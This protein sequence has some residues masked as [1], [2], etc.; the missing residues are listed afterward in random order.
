MNLNKLSKMLNVYCK[1]MIPGG[2]ADNSK[3]KFNPRA[4]NKGRKIEMEHTNDPEIAEE[5]AKDHLTED[6]EYYE[7]LEKY[8]EAFYRYAQDAQLDTPN[9]TI[10]PGRPEA[11]CALEIL[12]L[13]KP[14]YFIGVREII[15]G[16]SANYGYV[17]SG[18]DKDPA[19]IYINADR[20]V[21]ES[22]QQSGKAAALAAAEVIAHEKGHVDS[23]DENQGFVGGESPAEA[24]EQ[25][26]RQWLDS[27]GMNQIENLSCFKS[28]N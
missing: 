4:L 5:I 23:F 1:D 27:G 3:K 6:S 14:G 26:F 18:P 16:P 11:N 9:I 20:I 2:L 19:V 17:E 22:G 28:L 15:I 10:Q 12:K 25:E 8:V 13:W 7:K 21:A 24:Q